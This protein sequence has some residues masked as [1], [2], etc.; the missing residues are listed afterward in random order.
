MY[1]LWI[2]IG[3]DWKKTGHKSSSQEELAKHQT[4]DAAYKIT[5]MDLQN[6][7]AYAWE[8][9]VANPSRLHGMALDNAAA[10]AG[11]LRG[12]RYTNGGVEVTVRHCGIEVFRTFERGWGDEERAERAASAFIRGQMEILRLQSHHVEVAR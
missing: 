4:V 11:L 5:K 2:K 10:G 7:A 1:E 3:Q 9:Y 6:L 8:Q 12:G